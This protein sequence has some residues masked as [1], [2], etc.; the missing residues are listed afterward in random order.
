[1]TNRAR[2]AG[3][4]GHRQFCCGF[5]TLLQ[6]L[7]TSPLLPALQADASLLAW[8]WGAE[9]RRESLTKFITLLQTAG[10]ALAFATMFFTGYGYRVLVSRM[11]DH[12]LRKLLHMFSFSRQLLS[13]SSLSW[14]SFSGG[15][16]GV[17]AFPAFEKV[18]SITRLAAE[19]KARIIEYPQKR[20]RTCHLCTSASFNGVMLIAA[21]DLFSS[22]VI[23]GV[24][25]KLLSWSY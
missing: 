9:R 5:S 12:P 11:S 19:P 25:Q 1:M 18:F 24:H 22:G 14:L 3:A 23:C 6:L 8:P 4:R 7:V 16:S 13:R 2:L 10:S 17:P 20:S 15:P 21:R